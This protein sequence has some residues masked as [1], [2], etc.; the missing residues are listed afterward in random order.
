MDNVPALRRKLQRVQVSNLNLTRELERAERMLKA[1][2]TGWPRSFGSEA[3]HRVFDWGKE[4]RSESVWFD[5][6]TVV[7]QS[8]SLPSSV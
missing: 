7:L 6:T 3:Q 4:C 2:V 8:V 5:A 1:Q